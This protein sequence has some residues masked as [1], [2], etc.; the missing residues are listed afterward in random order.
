MRF[1][2]ILAAYGFLPALCFA[3]SA[4]AAPVMP[5]ADQVP[6]QIPPNQIP[7]DETL[8]QKDGVIASDAAPRPVRENGRDIYAPE[9]FARFNPRTALDMVVQ[10]PGFSISGSDAS[11]R[12]LGQASQNVL[13]NGKRISG[14]SNDAQTALGRIN[15]SDVERLEILDGAT[16]D[17]PGLSGQV[18]N[19]VVTRKGLSGNFRWN[20]RLRERIEDNLFEAEVSVSGKLGKGDFTLTLGNDAFRGGNFGIET[21]TAPDGSLLF[22]RDEIEI[23]RGDRPTVTLFYGRTS[24]AGS[25]FNFNGTAQIANFRNTTDTLRVETGLADIFEP[26]V[27]TEDERNFEVSADYEFALGGARLKL[28]GF[29][30]YEHSP[31]VSI[32]ENVFT[33]GRPTTGSRFAQTADEGES[34]LRSEYSW[35]S[36]NGND[37]Q[38]AL[39]G[40]FNFV[41]NQANLSVLDGQGVFVPE[42]LDNA[43][44]RVEE[45]RAEGTLSYGRKLARRLTLQANIGVEYS[46]LSQSGPLGLTRTFVRPKG[47]VALTWNASSNLDINARIERNV[48]QLNFFDFI[49]DVDLANDVGNAGNPQLVPEQSW[50]FE[51]EAQR[52]LGDFGNIT[53]R[54]F[55]NAI[56]DI[57]DRVPITATT[58]ARGNLDSAVRY[59]VEANGTLLFD[60]VGWKGARLDLALFYQRSSIDD[61]LTGIARRINGE[62][63]ATIQAD[64][65]HDIPGTQWAWGGALNR[66]F[67]ASAFRLDLRS[68]RFEIRPQ[69]SAFVENKDIFGLTVRASV[70]N[71]INQ[72][73]AFI[74]EISEDRRDGPLAFIER[75]TRRFGAVLGLDVSGTF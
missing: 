31:A 39:E 49:A 74:R 58:E 30:R 71:V 24:D 61:P 28:I 56:S 51:I 53:L 69:I 57:V 22:T 17:I 42:P 27:R 1:F 29:Q 52:N 8:S 43:T 9:A 46:Q 59:G 36:K 47:S 35:R 60:P 62:R 6:N 11:E 26:F 67:D 64:F 25:I 41:D 19:L 75:R 33:D 37:W 45:R 34:I 12:G 18:L 48:G 66:Q 4:Y 68:R 7:R 16:L 38:F 21:I 20:P 14:K 2:N 55:Y 23:N 3:G 10:I 40:A 65:R 50:D 72:R 13:I 70:R 54:G 5:Q 15:A 73:D 63:I 44:S 32:F